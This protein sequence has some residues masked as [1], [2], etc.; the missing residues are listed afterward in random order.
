MALIT[1]K[2]DNRNYETT[3][4]LVNGII[5][6]QP[7]QCPVNKTTGEVIP[8][9]LLK[10]VDGS[11]VRVLE[12]QI[13]NRPLNFPVKGIKCNIASY[14]VI[15]EVTDKSTGAKTKREVSNT[16]SADFAMTTGVA[17]GLNKGGLH[18]PEMD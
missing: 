6:L 8:T 4:V 5:N 15:V 9:C 17:I 10:L 3:E 14:N 16:Q 13:K 7:E 18:L 2:S 12:N 1:N 11:T